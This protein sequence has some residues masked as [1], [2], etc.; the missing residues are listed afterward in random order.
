MLTYNQ[1]ALVGR[2]IESIMAQ[3][4]SFRFELIIGDDGS[5]DGTQAVLRQY[6]ARYPE[7]ILLVLH[8]RHYEGEV[9]GRT[10]N[11]TNI[12]AC[13][14]KYVAVC[15]GDDYWLS[16][17]KLQRQYDLL[18]AR[19]DLALCYHNALRVP[20]GD[21]AGWRYRQRRL[22]HY[23][24]PKVPMGVYTHQDCIFNRHPSIPAS[25][26]FYR[27]ACLGPLPGWFREVIHADYFMHLLLTQHGD[28][29]YANRIDSAYVY[30]N[31]AMRE[32]YFN[33]LEYYINA[34]EEHRIASAVFPGYARAKA[35][36]RASLG[37]VGAYRLWRAGQYG[38]ALRW[39]LAAPRYDPLVYFKVFYQHLRT[40]I[41]RP[42]A[43]VVSPGRDAAPKTV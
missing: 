17:T 26:V 20:V 3:R 10:N 30:S 34:A 2:A 4:V 23:I 18:E 38:Q 5:T 36:R 41:A 9:P 16:D 7:H 29:H 8:P 37:C 19:P 21:Y 14:G 40:R 6:A 27:K 32:T 33:R 12:R 1:A 42:R 15:D 31:T 11:I 24:D 43:S 25:S 39:L 22:D 28:A 35:H 13:R